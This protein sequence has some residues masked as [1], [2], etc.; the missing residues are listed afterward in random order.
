MRF[1]YDGQNYK[2]N[3]NANKIYEQCLF[4]QLPDKRY[5]EVSEWF[6]SDPPQPKVM[7]EVPEYEIDAYALIT[8][9]ESC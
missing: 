8:Q 9:A 3:E 2:T 5:L 4:I 1:T 6:K 7:D